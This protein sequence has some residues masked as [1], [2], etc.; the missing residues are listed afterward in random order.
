MDDYWIWKL[1]DEIREVIKEMKKE[2]LEWY[3][4]TNHNGIPFA[5]RLDYYA[6]KLEEIVD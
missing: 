2:S 1:E 5:E 3:K 4:V 6:K